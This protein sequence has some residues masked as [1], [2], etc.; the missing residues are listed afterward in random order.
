M[1]RIRLLS[2]EMPD[3]L[4]MRNRSPGI[5]LSD[6]IGD[7]CLIQGLYQKSDPN[8]VRLQLGNAL[9]WAMIQRLQRHD[10]DRYAHFP[11]TE[12]DGIYITLDLL[13]RRL[14]RPN[15]FKL[16]DLSSSIQPGDP[17]FWKYETQVCAQS[18]AIGSQEGVVPVV[19]QRGNYKDVRDPVYHEWELAWSRDELRSNWDK[20]LRHRDRML[21]SEYWKRIE[22][23]GAR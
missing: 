5:H 4:P 8:M 14:W 19:H 2:S 20:L 23:G 13:D 1:T 21:K 7:M 16:T 11:E 6:I 15:E 9:E 12:R 22:Q 17:K 3:I 10:P 18:F